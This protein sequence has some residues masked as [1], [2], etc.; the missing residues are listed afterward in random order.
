MRLPFLSI[1][2]ASTIDGKI[3]PASRGP[4]KLGSAYD[5]RRMSELRAE[6]DGVVMG[7]G[8]FRAYPKPLKVRF[9]ALIRARIR[10]RQPEQPA[11]VIISSRLDLPKRVTP[12][13]QAHEVRRIVFTTRRAPAGKRT[14]LERAGVEVIVAPG[15]RPSPRFVLKKLASLGFRRVLLE[16]GGEVNASFFEA[17]LVNRIYLTLCPSLLGGSTA[18]TIFDGRGFAF[19]ERSFWR[20]R[21]A[22]K[23]GHEI[24]LIYDRA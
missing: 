17:G 12:F 9:P 13:E 11:T 5:S 20:L 24:Y 15:A 23:R 2:M 21:E 19:R 7:A 4:V 14:R 22:R 8:T 1:N 16:G 6:A 10:R 3:A 18:P